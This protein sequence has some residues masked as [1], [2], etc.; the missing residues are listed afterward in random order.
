[1]LPKFHISDRSVYQKQPLK[2][3]ETGWWN[4]YCCLHVHKS[5][6]YI[7]IS[8]KTES[9]LKGSQDIREKRHIWNII[10][11]LLTH[12]QS[13]R[14][15]HVFSTAE[16]VRLK[17]W[18]INPPVQCFWRLLKRSEPIFFWPCQYIDEIPV[19]TYIRN[20]IVSGSAAMT[21]WRN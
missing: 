14:T 7:A 10:T 21:L 13:L 18:K 6:F 15:K 11:A 2:R 19:A 4:N 8:S 5:F 9:N 20:I 3:Q 17:S 1:M 16:L 12:H